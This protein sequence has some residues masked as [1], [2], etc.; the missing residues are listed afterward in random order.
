MSNSEGIYDVRRGNVTII[1]KIVAGGF[2][3]YAT[4]GVNGDEKSRAVTQPA[5][6]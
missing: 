6:S 4:T 2:A 1:V 5:T 3:V